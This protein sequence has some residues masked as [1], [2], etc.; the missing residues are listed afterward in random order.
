MP[1]RRG[2]PYFELEIR[3]D[4]IGDAAGQRRW[5]DLLAEVLPAAW[6]ERRRRK[7]AHRPGMKLRVVTWNINSLRLRLPLLDRLM[8]ALDPDV[9][10]LQ[11]TKVPDD[12]VPGRRPGA[13]RLSATS[14]G[15]A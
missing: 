10:C 6:I 12:A 13:P 1:I 8:A 3:Q 5:A 11:E 7:A 2:L 4:L 9:I 14:P 15:A